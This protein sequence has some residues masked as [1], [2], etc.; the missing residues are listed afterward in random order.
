[1]KHDNLHP[2]EW[3]AVMALLLFLAV[4]IQS[5]WRAPDS[6]WPEKEGR[7]L[8]AP[9]EQLVVTFTGAIAKE[10]RYHFKAGTTLGEALKEI[11]LLPEAN[12]S[13]MA[14]EKPLKRSQRIRIPSKKSTKSQ[15]KFSAVQNESS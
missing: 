15:A 2:H 5:A 12:T 3:M 13:K 14:L 8:A 4:L 7:A 11:E 10:G 1:M 6:R 9:H